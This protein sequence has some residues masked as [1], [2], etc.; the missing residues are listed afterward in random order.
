M[1]WLPGNRDFS[2]FIFR[3]FGSPI[4]PPIVCPSETTKE[5]QERFSPKFLQDRFSPKFLQERFS[6]KFLQERFS[7]KF[8]SRK[9]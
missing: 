4:I 2:S 7:P 6:P 1:P 3:R 5:L 8:L 9:I